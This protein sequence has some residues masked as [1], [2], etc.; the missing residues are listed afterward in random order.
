MVGR[1]SAARRGIERG[2]VLPETMLGAQRGAP[3]G[4]HV[5]AGEHRQHAVADQLEHVAASIVDGVDR[6]LRVVVEKR[7]DLVGRDAFADRGR[8]AQIGKPQHGIDPLGDAAR[9][10]PAQDLLGG[11]APEIDPAQRS[12]DLHL[13][14]RLDRQPQHRHEIAQRRQARSSK[15]SARRVTQ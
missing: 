7:D 11:V 6:G 12:G 1:P 3:G 4:R 13:G 10:P 14:G 15:P 2:H 5:I 8:A 9:Y